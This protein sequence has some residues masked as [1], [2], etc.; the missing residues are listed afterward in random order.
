MAGL[1]TAKADQGHVAIAVN[2]HDRVKD[3]ER[4]A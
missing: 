2:A 3:N 4:R 1:L